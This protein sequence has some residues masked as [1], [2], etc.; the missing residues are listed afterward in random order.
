MVERR[1]TETELRAML[2]FPARSIPD[3][4]RRPNCRYLIGGGILA[5]VNEV[6]KAV[7]TVGLDG[8]DRHNWQDLAVR[9]PPVV[10]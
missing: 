6:E 4:K 3:P 8:A 7:I 5:V 9:R 1:I 10:P 2:E